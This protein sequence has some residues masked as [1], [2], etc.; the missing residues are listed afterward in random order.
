[1]ELILLLAIVVLIF[2]GKNLASLGEG[3]GKAVSA[4][5]TQSRPSASGR[6]GGGRTGKV[7]RGADS[8]GAGP[9]A[10]DQAKADKIR[11][12]A[13]GPVWDGLSLPA[14][15]LL[16]QGVPFL[17]ARP[18]PGNVLFP[19]DGFPLIQNDP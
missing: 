2:G 14:L 17:P 16:P 4:L 13:L 5:N 11:N 18:R 9:G 6:S 15:G 19:P 8:A 10:E 3:L 7:L 12:I 1:M